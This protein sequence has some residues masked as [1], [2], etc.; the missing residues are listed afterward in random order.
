M[1]VTIR[2]ATLCDRPQLWRAIIELQEFERQ[3]D[4]TAQLPGDQIADAYL[5]WMLKHAENA[6]AV[7]VAESAGRFVG[8]VADWVEQSDNIAENA[9]TNRFGFVSDIC[10][11]PEFRGQRIATQLL[12]AI[13]RYLRCSGVTR[14]RLNM[15]VA[16]ASARASYQRAGFAPYEIVFE[17]I[18]GE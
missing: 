6:G 12:G 8:F 4:P 18:L 11:M 3:L 17:K 15:L 10:I 5:I 13:E 1:D 2:L 7:F 9:D 14:L 16:N